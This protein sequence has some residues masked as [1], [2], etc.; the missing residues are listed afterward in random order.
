MSRANAIGRVSHGAHDA[1]SEC[2]F[3]ADP[4]YKSVN[5]GK[6]VKNAADCG[7]DAGTSTVMTA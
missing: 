1:G 5:M 7:A 4:L 2:P 3:C 6:P